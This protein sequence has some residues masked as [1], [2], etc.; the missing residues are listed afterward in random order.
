[1]SVVDRKRHECGL[2]PATATG[3][4]ITHTLQYFER[5][6]KLGSQLAAALHLKRRHWPMKEMKPNPLDWRKL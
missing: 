4:H 5:T 1:M 2:P 3:K 6:K